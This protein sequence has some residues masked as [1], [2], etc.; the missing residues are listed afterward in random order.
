[1]HTCIDTHL[2]NSTLSPDYRQF[3]KRTPAQAHIHI[4]VRLQHPLREHAHMCACDDAQVLDDDR[5]STHHNSMTQT[6]RPFIIAFA[7]PKGGVG[8]STSCLNIASA[9]CAH[10]YPVHIIDLDQ[11]QSLYGW[12]TNHNPDIPGLSI[13]S[14]PE[15]SFIE[16]LKKATNSQS[17]FILID[18][19]GAM[20]QGMIQA[21]T[22]ADLTI[23]PTKLSSLDLLEADKLHQ[24][25][26]SVAQE[27][28]TT[29]NHRIL[30]NEVAHLLPGYQ[31]HALDQIAHGS[32]PRFETLI[33]NRAP[34][35]ESFMTG[36]PPH[37]ANRD[38]PPV[39]KAIE[40]IDALLVEV[41]AAL[42]LNQQ[43]KAAA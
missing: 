10:G 26:L 5:P 20:G 38:R 22:I 36:K 40:E 15:A 8:K 25:I 6:T 18:V 23:T 9:I 19:A 29:I 1:M 28:G 34:Y 3:C 16:T 33:R 13:E 43:Q 11:T 12:F 24:K 39:Q 41:F 27:V 31:A 32:L 42:G 37:F 30:I 21:A 7:S 2:H 14:V 17:G 4:C 35:A